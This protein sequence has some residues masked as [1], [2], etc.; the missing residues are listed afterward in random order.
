MSPPTRSNKKSRA[1]RAQNGKNC[2]GPKNLSKKGTISAQEVKWNMRY[3]ELKKFKEE[4]KHC[5]VPQRCSA[6]RQ[7][8]EW[9]NNQ[10][11]LCKKGK[12]REDRINDLDSIGFCWGNLNDKWDQQFKELKKFKEEKGHC[13]VPQGYSAN[14]QLGIWVHNQRTLCKKGTISDDRIS[15][16]EK[17]GFLWGSLEERWN[18]RYEELKKFKE[19]NGHCN[20]P[21]RY[22]ANR[23]LGIWVNEQRALFKKGKLRVNRIEYL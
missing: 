11:A 9:V 14:R 15:R 7:L 21:Y 6:N 5:N 4:N 16:L 12:L 22:S 1:Q 18:M 10:R 17:I 19:E 13:I 8:G 2:D 23:Q 3:E 20:V